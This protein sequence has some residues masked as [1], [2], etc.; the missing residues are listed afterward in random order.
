[1][2]TRWQIISR[3]NKG[4]KMGQTTQKNTLGSPSNYLYIHFLEHRKV[5]EGVHQHRGHRLVHG[6]DAR[7]PVSW[8][9]RRRLDRLHLP[10]HH[11]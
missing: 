6:H 7:D 4:S 2:A 3:K 8:R 10:L 11:R 5:E 9:Q 1:M